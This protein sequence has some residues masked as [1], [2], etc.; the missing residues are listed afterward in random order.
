MGELGAFLKIARSGSVQ[1]DPCERVGDY[2]EFVTPLPDAEL[3]AQGA[4]CMDCGVPFCHNGCPV[5][6]LI[7]DWND[8][9]YRDRWKEA[10]VQLHA[11]NNFPD[12]TGRACPAPCE[13][14]CVMEIREGEAVT[15]KQIALALARAPGLAPLGAPA[16]AVTAAVGG[17]L[18]IR[19]LVLALRAVGP[20]AS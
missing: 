16:A 7:P 17:L 8:L 13:A 4:R 6:N 20:T 1:R 9:V 14:A 11:T 10:I 5:G 18:A 2:R 15:I 12:F 3:R 19:V